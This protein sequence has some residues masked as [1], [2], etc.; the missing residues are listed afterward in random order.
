[1]GR[2]V[3]ILLVV[4]A[5]LFSVFACLQAESPNAPGVTKT[6]Y[7]GG[8]AGVIAAIDKLID[9]YDNGV[10]TADEIIIK[11]QE[12]IPEPAG[13]PERSIEFIVPAGEGSS[14]DNYARNI[15][16]DA[17]LLMNQ[18]VYFNNLPGG[19]GEI[20]LQY[21]LQAPA[22][23]YTLY[24][25]SVEQ[26][27]NEAQNRHT[28]SFSKDVSFI[29]AGQNTVEAYWVAADSPFKNMNE[30]LSYAAAHPGQ[31]K[32]C[33]GGSATDGYYKV[34]SLARE[35]NTDITYLAVDGLSEKMAVLLERKADLLLETAGAAWPFYQD[36]TIRPLAFSQS[37]AFDDIDPDLPSVQ[38]LGFQVPSELWRGIVTVKGTDSQ[39]VN[40]LYR[41][42]YAA[43]KLPYYRVYETNFKYFFYTNYLD[44]AHFKAYVAGEVKRLRR[45]AGQAPQIAKDE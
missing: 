19:A 37:A 13:Y 40:Y 31:L 6:S 43:S 20:G 14:A 44:P 24:V 45:L 7:H 12:V 42:F 29:I 39:V 9:Q 34:L 16:R 10:F 5:V 15:C 33:G 25:A 1:M 17:A 35:L 32:I 41:C 8:Q 2:Q 36:K 26:S 3:S 21:L 18:A 27:V 28:Y 11:L 30:A 4:T 38:S 22:D 23:G